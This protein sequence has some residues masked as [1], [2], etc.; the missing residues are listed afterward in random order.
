VC[1]L[2]LPTS[3]CLFQ[4]KLQQQQKTNER[5][6]E[7]KAYATRVPLMLQNQHVVHFLEVLEKCFESMKRVFPRETQRTESL[8][9]PEHGTKAI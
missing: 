7:N 2:S 5:I 3:S 4:E 8:N 9:I 1:R 6:E